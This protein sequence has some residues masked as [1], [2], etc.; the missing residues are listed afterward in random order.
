MLVKEGSVKDPEDGAVYR[1]LT[2][3]EATEEMIELLV[4][5]LERKEKMKVTRVGNAFIVERRSK[6]ARGE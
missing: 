2:I 4:R 1:K 6:D 3:S 5:I